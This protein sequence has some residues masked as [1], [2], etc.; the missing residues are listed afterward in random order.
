MMK[1]EL[2]TIFSQGFQSGTFLRVGKNREISLYIGKDEN[3]NYAF[4]FRGI[5]VPVR[6]SQS[7]VIM[8]QQGTNG[9][10]YILRFSL[11]NHELLEYFCT[12]CQDLL[13][14]TES[15]KMDEDAYKILCERYFSWRKLFRPNSGRMTDSEIMGLIGELLFMQD[16]M[17][18]QF[19]VEVALESWMGPEKTHKDYSIGNFWYE[20]KT[21]NAGKNSVKIASVEQLDGENEGFLIVYCLEKM[22]PSFS[23]VKLNA[24]V[25]SLMKKMGTP[26]NRE[27]FMSKL[28]LYDFDFAPEYDNY[29]FANV[30]FSMYSI[31]LGF[32]RLCR[33]DIPNAINKIQYEI[34]LSEIENFKNIK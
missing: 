15:V 32:P 9:D 31:G 7:D 1:N 30:G 20:I 18:P 3:G 4:E 24:L 19:G 33:K 34:I 25:Q 8:V 5:Y 11:C 14:S 6:I 10:R 26:Q 29:V 2:L 22:S 13:D 16:Y 27:L 17:I 12:F 28:S 23:G 21:I